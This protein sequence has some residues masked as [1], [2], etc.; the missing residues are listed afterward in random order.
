MIFDDL[1]AAKRAA[2]FAALNSGFRYCVYQ[3]KD[4]FISCGYW[5]AVTTDK[6]IIYITESKK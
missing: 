2:D 6:N 4:G 5:A 3:S 1:E